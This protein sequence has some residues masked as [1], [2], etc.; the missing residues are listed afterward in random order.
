MYGRLRLRNYAFGIYDRPPLFTFQYAE[1]VGFQFISV[2]QLALPQ[3]SEVALRTSNFLATPAPSYIGQRGDRP[4]E[5]RGGAD[6]DQEIGPS[7]G[8]R[9]TA[10]ITPALWIGHREDRNA[11]GGL[12]ICA[13]RE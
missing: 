7:S 10:L 6:P 13:I 8:E 1:K 12:R 5:Y 9:H 4:A 3:N 11:L 2:S